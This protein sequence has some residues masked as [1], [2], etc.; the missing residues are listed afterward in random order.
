MKILNPLLSLSFL[1]AVTNFAFSQDEGASDN[2]PGKPPAETSN[3]F[4]E[5]FEE[6]NPEIDEDDPNY[7]AFQEVKEKMQEIF[8]PGENTN[9]PDTSSA[10]GSWLLLG[11]SKPFLCTTD[12]RIYGPSR[13]NAFET[14][15]FLN[16]F[17]SEPLFLEN[18]EEVSVEIRPFFRG[19][20]NPDGNKTLP[21]NANQIGLVLG[22]RKQLPLSFV[23]AELLYGRSCLSL[24]D[25]SDEVDDHNVML[26][27]TGGLFRTH[28]SG[29]LTFSVGGTF[30]DMNKREAKKRKS[31][32]K[33]FVVGAG[34][35]VVFYPPSF[36]LDFFIGGDLFYVHGFGFEE[37]Q[38]EDK[39][40]CKL[41]YEI[42][43]HFLWRVKAGPS[44]TFKRSSEKR[45]YQLVSSFATNV[46]SAFANR[47]SFHPSLL[48]ESQG[49]EKHGG[50]LLKLG[51]E[52]SKDRGAVDLAYG[53][54]F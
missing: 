46:Q 15:A 26:G 47:I 19:G 37:T 28:V 21:Y 40:S 48:F 6:S 50:W 16:T 33:A 22:L 23:S 12:E 9:P 39:Y 29:S 38:K 43:N 13:L 34:P 54:H 14:N 10:N 20:K 8:G 24:K 25:T 31:Q 7:I 49:H 18:K 42:S 51:Y 30:S 52:F 11:T 45:L 27:V 1:I 41:D 2:Y 53:L 35:L 5:H 17:A 32:P 4:R 44:Y 36:P 3:L